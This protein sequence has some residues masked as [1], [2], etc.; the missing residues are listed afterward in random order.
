MADQL[1]NS[2]PLFISIK[3]GTEANPNS[4]R[5]IEFSNPNTTMKFGKMH[6]MITLICR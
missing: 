1:I 4:F 6:F 5:R 2:V 3:N